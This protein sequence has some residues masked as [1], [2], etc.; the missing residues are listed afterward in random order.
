MK[1][2]KKILVL[3]LAALLLV[4]V[5]VGGTLAWLTATSGPVTNTFTPA[6]ISVN[7]DEH[8]YNKA[9]N[10][11]DETV[12]PVN[13]NNDYMMVPGR[14]IKKDPMVDASSDVD[15]YVFVTVEKENWPTY[16]TYEIDGTNWEQVSGENDVYYYKKNI[17]A[18]V[19]GKYS[20]TDVHVLKDDKVH[21]ADTLKA[22][23]MV[24]EAPQLIFNA[25]AIQKE[26][27]G[28]AAEAWAKAKPTTT[29]P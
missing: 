25:Y 24:G 19:N 1:N 16:L 22:E 8:K 7:I 21:V 6:T 28:T 26:G 20:I 15:F 5:G 29:N 23:D 9:T 10:S 11:L 13:G 18:D 27:T 3:A 17:T 14:D 2:M 4:A 12:P